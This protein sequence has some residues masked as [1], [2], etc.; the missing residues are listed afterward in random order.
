[1]FDTQRRVSPIQDDE[2]QGAGNYFIYTRL[3]DLNLDR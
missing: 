1:M 3:M 2:N